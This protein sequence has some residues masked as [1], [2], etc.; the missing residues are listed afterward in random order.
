MPFAIKTGRP[1][2]SGS[3]CALLFSSAAAGSLCP[4]TNAWADA[5]A[6]SD[7]TQLEDVV[8]TAR[9]REERLLDVPVAIT[10]ITA[11]EVQRYNVTNI[12]AIKLVAP[13]VSF[14]RAFTGSG[15]SIALR[16]VSSSS[17]DAGLEQS[18]LLDYDGMPLSRGRVLSDALFDID[19]VD[20]LK[21]P[22]SLFFG[23]NTPGGVVSVR[24]AGPTKDLQGFAVSY[25][26]LTLPTIYSV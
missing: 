21:G 12:Q 9:R 14:D 24:T 17:L 2:L 23:K 26:H 7:A 4:A 13:Q 16:G 5:P 22:Q 25:T 6:A 15:T 20:V 19:G 11:Q 3:L 10:A 18:V 8:V 1:R